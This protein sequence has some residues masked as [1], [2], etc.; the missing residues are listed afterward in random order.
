MIYVADQYKREAKDI[1]P[2]LLERRHELQEVARYHA[3]GAG[4][5]QEGVLAVLSL[6][7]CALAAPGDRRG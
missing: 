3:Q 2:G 7:A 1:A 4:G 6:S 5:P